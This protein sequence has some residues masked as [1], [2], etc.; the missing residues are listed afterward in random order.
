MTTWQIGERV[1]VAGCDGLFL[2]IGVAESQQLVDLVSL[3]NTRQVEWAVP[4]DSI[5]EEDGGT[6]A[7]RSA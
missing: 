5:I 6:R 7:E 2:I 3:E 1:R 4:A